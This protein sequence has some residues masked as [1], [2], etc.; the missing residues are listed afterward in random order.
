M[1]RR[2]HSNGV[3][4]RRLTCECLKH[5]ETRVC[6]I[7]N[8]WVDSGDIVDLRAFV[9]TLGFLGYYVAFR[10]RPGRAVWK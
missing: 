1:A 8:R 6:L 3:H 7:A 2:D 10:D 5:A 9:G 4:I